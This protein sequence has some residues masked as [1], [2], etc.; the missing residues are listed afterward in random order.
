MNNDLKEPKPI[1]K[2][3]EL[4]LILI[5][6]VGLLALCILSTACI[7]SY[8]FFQNKKYERKVETIREM[9]VKQLRGE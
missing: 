6:I 7:V 9:E 1:E 8:S 5:A 3:S 2:K 4:R